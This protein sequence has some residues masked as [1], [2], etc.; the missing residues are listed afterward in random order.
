MDTFFI[1]TGYLFWSMML[2]ERGRPRW[3]GLYINRI[4]RIGPMFSLAVVLMIAILVFQTGSSL[5]V[6]L[7]NL[8][9]E[10][11]R[12]M[13]I[14]ILIGGT[15]NGYGQPS[16]IMAGV[17]WTLQYEWAFYM[18]LMLMPIGALDQKAVLPFAVATMAL[19]LLWW[20]NG[21]P[22]FLAANDAIM[23]IL[24]S[25]GIMTAALEAKGLTL[26]RVPDIGLSAGVLVLVVL[27][28]VLFPNGYGLA[29]IALLG[30]AFYFV[31]SG[32]TFFGLLT[33]RPARRLGDISYGLYL[34]QGPVLTIVL[35]PHVIRD[36]ALSGAFAYWTVTTGAAV[37]LASLATLSHHLVERPGIR[38]G[39]TLVEAVQRARVTGLGLDAAHQR[40]TGRSA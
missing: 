4:F 12:W 21:G 35:A 22:F 20:W 28:F 24:F 11:G 15:L 23:A 36:F 37:L 13:S 40:P 10:I 8:V 9:Q 25:I 34:L 6:S 19:S 18:A 27:V 29:P 31:I 5:Q 1:I 38:A 32:G 2:R 33:S 16:L 30:A 39:K 3:V 26:A 7:T 14:G 17:T